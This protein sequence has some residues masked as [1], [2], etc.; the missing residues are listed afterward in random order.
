MDLDGNLDYIYR[1]EPD[2]FYVSDGRWDHSDGSSHDDAFELSDF[3]DSDES[4]SAE[5]RSRNDDL[6]KMAEGLWDY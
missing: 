2:D 5:E 3:Y 4:E 6:F 1:P